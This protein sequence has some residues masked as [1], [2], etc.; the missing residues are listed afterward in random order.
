M[1]R[2]TSFSLLAEWFDDCVFSN[3]ILIS[4]K[5]TLYWAHTKHCKSEKKFEVQVAMAKLV[6]FFFSNSVGLS[7]STQQSFLISKNTYT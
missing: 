4:T 5:S 1:I 3:T 7:S 6:G 2:Y